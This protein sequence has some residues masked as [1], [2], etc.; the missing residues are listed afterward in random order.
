MTNEQII[1]SLDAMLENPKAKNFLNHIVRSYFPSSKIEKVWDKPT[2]DFKCALTRKPLISIEEIFE[3][4]NSQEYKDEFLNGLKLAFNDDGTMVPPIKKFV[5]E[6]KLGFTGKDTTTYLSPDAL[7]VFVDWVINKA[8]LGDKH[9]NWLLN[10]VRRADYLER[11]K[12]SSNLEVQ[13]KANKEK[14]STKSASFKMG[15]ANSALA[16]LKAKMEAEE[17]A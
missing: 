6:R 1:S 10:G 8:F 14:T 13:A 3:I 17:K 15:D 5:G 16:S 7:Q 4:N 12:N 11:A 9:I 2:G